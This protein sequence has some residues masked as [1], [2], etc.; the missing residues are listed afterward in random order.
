MA[1]YYDHC[2]G[3]V[4]KPV[5][6]CDKNGVDDP[7]D[8]GSLQI[9]NDGYIWVFVSGR[10]TMRP[11][12]IYRS[13]HPGKIDAFELVDEQEVTYPQPWW[14]PERGFLFLFT[15][16]TDGLKGS[17][18]ELFWK[19]SQDGQAWSDDTKLAGFGGHYQVSACQNG[20]VATFFNW[21]PDS[22]NNE[23]TNLYYAE[24]SDFGE[25]WTSANG[26][27]LSLPLDKPSNNALVID[28]K[29]DGRLV[30]TC[31][32]NFDEQGN[33]ILLYVCSRD[34]NPGPQGDPREWRVTY[35]DGRVWRTSTVAVSTHNYDVGSLYVEDGQWRIIGPTGAGPD[36]IGTGGEVTIWISTDRGQTWCREQSVTSNSQTNHSHVRRPLNARDPFYAFWAD[37]DTLM[38]S[39][40]HLFFCDYS[41]KLVYQLPYSFEGQFARPE[42]VFTA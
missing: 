9:D 3:E 24:S 16:Y 39:P 32:L 5:I 34:G 33:P 2:T 40:S 35:W 6:V 22:E 30:Y 42:R 38:H 41:G 28:Y 21:H 17:A 37:G 13:R 25:T 15:K 19:T 12:L 20:K 1:S 4:P 7:H 29:A 8:N 23:R 36:P 14:I 11:G 26:D 10:N 31:D 27:A 18:R